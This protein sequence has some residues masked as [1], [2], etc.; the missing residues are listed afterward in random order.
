MSRILKELVEV[1]EGL[2]KGSQLDK[3]GEE[4]LK[5]ARQELASEDTAQ[6]E[7][8]RLYRLCSARQSA[9]S[10]VFLE[11]D[12]SKEEVTVEGWGGWEMDGC[13]RLYKK[14][15]WL[16]IVHNANEDTSVGQFT[17]DFKKN[18]TKIIE[19]YANL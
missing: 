19:A 1:A 14:I 13:D 11:F 16:P 3:A 9:A 2:A 5:K 17:V 8:D 15:Y 10:D 4:V 12:F 18:S 7:H 6:A